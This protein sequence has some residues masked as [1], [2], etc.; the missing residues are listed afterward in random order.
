MW[1]LSDRERCSGTAGNRILFSS[2]CD[3]EIYEL[4]SVKTKMLAP[5]LNVPEPVFFFQIGRPV[6]QIVT[7]CLPQ[8][9]FPTDLLLAV[10]KSHRVMD[11]ALGQVFFLAMFLLS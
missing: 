5:V 3:A 7:L 4:K 8:V 9:A 11:E 6:R 2:G 1:L 10:F